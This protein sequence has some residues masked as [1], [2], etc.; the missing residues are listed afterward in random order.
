MSMLGKIDA[1]CIVVLFSA[2][3]IGGLIC[4]FSGIGPWEGIKGKIPVLC[5]MAAMVLGIVTFIWAVWTI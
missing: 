5:G 3:W 2:L 1:T 4:A